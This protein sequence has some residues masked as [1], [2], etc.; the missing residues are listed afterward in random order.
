[1]KISSRTGRITTA[2]ALVGVFVV[3]GGVSSTSASTGRKVSVTSKPPALTVNTLR[4]KNAALPTTV[5]PAKKATTTTVKPRVK[6]GVPK[7][8]TAQPQK[9]SGK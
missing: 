9:G 7:G 8:S 2:V 6:N 4:T 3:G 1:M 5:A